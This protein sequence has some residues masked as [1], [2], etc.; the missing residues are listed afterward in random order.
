MRNRFKTSLLKS[1]A[2]EYQVDLVLKEIRG[3]IYDGM[4]TRQLYQWA[5]EL[6]MSYS[7]AYAARYS[8]KKGTYE[9]GTRRLLF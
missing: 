6:L 3:K 5:H 4:R 8:L 7:N 9:A 1:G 2:P